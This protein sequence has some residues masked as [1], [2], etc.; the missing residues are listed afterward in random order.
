MIRIVRIKLSIKTNSEFLTRVT[1][2]QNGNSF[3]VGERILSPRAEDQVT[4]TDLVLVSDDLGSFK[5]YRDT[6]RET[7]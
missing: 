4:V 3:T 6:S 2:L 5:Y 1:S 7:D